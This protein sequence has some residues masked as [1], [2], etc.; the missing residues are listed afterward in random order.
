[1]TIALLVFL[2]LFLCAIW[3]HDLIKLGQSVGTK[4]YAWRLADFLITSFAIMAFVTLMWR[5]M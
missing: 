5:W 4:N 1:M 2:T 3:T